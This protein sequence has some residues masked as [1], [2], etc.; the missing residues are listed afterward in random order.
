MDILEAQI[1]QEALDRFK[2]RDSPGPKFTTAAGR[3]MVEQL[4]A[5]L[6][7]VQVTL[8]AVT[9]IARGANGKFRLVVCNLSAQELERLSKAK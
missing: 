5:R 9:E 2:L 7:P 8:E 3:E 1:I 4:Q 6:G